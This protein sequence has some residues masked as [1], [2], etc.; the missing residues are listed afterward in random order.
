MEA[1][2][3]SILSNTGGNLSNTEGNASRALVSV[4]VPVYN[5]RPFLPY[6]LRSIAAQT[7]RNIE[8]I[9]VDDGSTDG[10][11]ELCDEFASSDSRFKVVHQPNG[12]Q[13]SARNA[14]FSLCSGEWVAFVDGDDF[15]H[16]E[17]I[18]Y[19]LEAA[20]STGSSL[21]VCEYEPVSDY[22]VPM[23]DDGEPVATVD[24]SDALLGKMLSGL[25]VQYMT[26]WG[27]LFKRSLIAPFRFKDRKCEDT[28]YLSQVFPTVDRAAHIRNRLYFYYSRPGS[29]STGGIFKQSQITLLSEI[30]ERYRDSYPAHSKQ[31]AR[32]ILVQTEKYYRRVGM[33]DDGIVDRCKREAW[34]VTFGEEGFSVNKAK[35]WFRLFHPRLYLFLRG[36]KLR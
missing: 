36:R 32:L 9:L 19:L 5:I 21:S 26:V 10:S 33:F 29:D 28:E 34:K 20:V 3:D 27:K 25:K 35:T 11:G 8:V 17:Y 31:A 6:C 2:Q 23:P 15:M 22:N 18:R 14:G 16:P 7:Y 24:D 12:G 4:I 30:M 13:S 1:S